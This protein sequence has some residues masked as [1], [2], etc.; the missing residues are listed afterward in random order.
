VQD[1][2]IIL[3]FDTLSFGPAADD[4]EAAEGELEG[5]AERSSTVP[6]ISTLWPTCAVSFESSPS[7]VY[8]LAIGRD[9]PLVPAVD[10]ELLVAAMALFSVN[11]A[12]LAAAGA[13]APLVPVGAGVAF[14]RQPVTVTVFALSEERCVGC[15]ADGVDGVDG[16]CPL[17]VGVCAERLTAIAHATTPAA[18]N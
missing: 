11:L 13:P 15:D 5:L 9:A 18:P 14:S 17:G 4:D 12:L 3:T 10:G 6:V 16:V 2:A 7:N 1:D 8:E